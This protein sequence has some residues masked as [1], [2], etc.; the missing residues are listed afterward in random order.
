M[1]QRLQ[2]TCLHRIVIAV[3]GL[4]F[5]LGESALGQGTASI[6]GTVQAQDGTPIAGVTISYGQMA[7]PRGKAAGAM[8]A[9]VHQLSS[10]SDGGFLIQSLKAGVYLV[11]VSAGRQ[12]YLDPCHWSSTP[13]TF[14]VVDGQAI[15]KAVISLAKGRQ[16]QIRVNDPLQNFSQESKSQGAYLTLAIRS[17]SGA[18]HT[19][20]VASSDSSG[21][22]YTVTIPPDTPVNLSI[23]PGTFQLSDSTGLAVASAGGQ[24][25]ITAPSSG[26]SSGLTFTLNG[27]GK[28]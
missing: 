8:M 4:A 13:V 16:Y 28:P 6:Q 11:C 9:P 25:Q 15:T 23:L 18:V 7:P 24:Y 26:A 21:R 3:F 2:A 14:T 12:P 17:F 20:V 10:G 22:S 1:S 19:A 5:V 27:V